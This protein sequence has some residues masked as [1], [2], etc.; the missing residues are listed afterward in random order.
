M[1]QPGKCLR[2][3][4]AAALQHFHQRSNSQL[5]VQPF[6]TRRTLQ[7]LNATCQPIYSTCGRSPCLL[8]ASRNVLAMS[9]PLQSALFSANCNRGQ[10][11]VAAV[12]CPLFSKD[13]RELQATVALAS[14][15]PPMETEA[16]HARPSF[17]SLL[18][19]GKQHKKA[20][21]PQKFKINGDQSAVSTTHHK[22]LLLH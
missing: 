9:R 22:T 10:R 2:N 6:N 20:T 19:R 14:L 3:L 7:A 12:A 1:R 11:H 13:S 8:A 4:P 16:G 5:L 17:A 15:L 21:E 18:Q